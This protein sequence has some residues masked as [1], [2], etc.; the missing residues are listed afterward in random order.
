MILLLYGYML[1]T[2]NMCDSENTRAWIG[3]TFKPR[4]EP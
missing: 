2:D 1:R 3:V 4:H